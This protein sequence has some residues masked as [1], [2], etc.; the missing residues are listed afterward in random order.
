MKRRDEYGLP[1]D[2]QTSVC[3][4]GKKGR[5]RCGGGG[6]ARK[7]RSSSLLPR[8]SVCC[9]A[10][11]SIWSLSTARVTTSSSS[12]YCRDWG[13]SSTL[14]VSSSSEE[15]WSSVEARSAGRSCSSLTASSPGAGARSGGSGRRQGLACL[16]FLLQIE[17]WAPRVQTPLCLGSS[18]TWTT[19]LTRENP[20]HK[21]GFSGAE[22]TQ[23]QALTIGAISFLLNAA[24]ACSAPKQAT[25][26]L[27]VSPAVMKRL[28]GD[29][30]GL[31]KRDLPSPL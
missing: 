10:G 19:G 2:L 20:I 3:R 5:L 1:H 7:K 16:H 18:G 14:T 13:G 29:T 9:S 26:C 30:H 24:A 31:N 11:Q 12:S 25:H 4:S 28:Q 23:R 15:E 8:D 21:Q 22:R 27:C 6:R 17:L